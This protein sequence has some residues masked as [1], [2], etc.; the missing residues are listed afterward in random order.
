MVRT[1]CALGLGLLA[2]GGGMILAVLLQTGI[3][4]VILGF[5]FLAIGACLLCGNGA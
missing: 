2:L 5:L 3:C 4:S 1:R